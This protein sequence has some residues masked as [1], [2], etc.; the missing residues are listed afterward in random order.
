MTGV[1]LDTPT[2]TQKQTHPRP[3][4]RHPLG[5]R[6]RH[7]TRPRGRHPPDPEPDTPQTQR[8]TPLDPEA[9]TPQRRQYTSY[10][11]AFLL[12]TKLTKFKPETKY[13]VKYNSNIFICNGLRFSFHLLIKDLG[14]RTIFSYSEIQYFYNWLHCF[15]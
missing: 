12:N 14:M 7:P 1:V 15:I 5:P 10:W 4:G 11:N 6:G 8:Q 3:R 9:D 2:W 13:N